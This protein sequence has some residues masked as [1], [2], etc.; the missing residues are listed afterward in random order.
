MLIESPLHSQKIGVWCALS[1]RKI[2]GL[3][4]FTESINSKEYIKM[5][6]KFVSKLNKE[7]VHG[8]YFQQDGATAH[9]SE[10]TASH[11]IS[12]FGGRLISK[13]SPD[14]GLLALPI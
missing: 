8:A 1:R 5:L 9:T 11:L 12:Y 7:E 2:I 13:N 4:F 3:I 14:N 6:H 10:E